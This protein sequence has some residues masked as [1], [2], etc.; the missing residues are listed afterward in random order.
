MKN[1]KKLVTNK[2]E[3][4]PFQKSYNMHNYVTLMT[5]FK[6]TK[7]TRRTHYAPSCPV[8]D[9]TLAHVPVCLNLPRPVFHHLQCCILSHEQVCNATNMSSLATR[10]SVLCM[11]PY[12]QQNTE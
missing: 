8:E 10:G 3:R 9:S 4:N 1:Y 6:G 5:K 2:L 7:G 11:K 12:Y